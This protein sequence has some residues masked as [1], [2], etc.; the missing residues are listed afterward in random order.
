M[1]TWEE[2]NHYLK[3]NEE[4]LH[5]LDNDHMV[6]DGKERK[7]RLFSKV[8]QNT[9]AANDPIEDRS[10][11]VL[12][13][14][15]CFLGVFDGH[16]GDGC[17]QFLTEHLVDYTKFR[18][19]MRM[20]IKKQMK[21]RYPSVNFESMT[22]QE[23]DYEIANAL[24]ERQ[25]KLFVDMRNMF[26]YSNG[27]PLVLKESFVYTDSVYCKGSLVRM[28]RDRQLLPNDLSGSCAILAYIQRNQMWI[29]NTGDCRAVLA[30]RDANTNEL[31]AV[32]L[33]FDQTA[34]SEEQRLRAEFPNE[35]DIVLDG[36]IKGGLQPS[37]SFGDIMYKEP[38]IGILLPDLVKHQRQWNPPYV[39]S[40]PSIH[41]EE[42]NVATDEFIVIA[43][44]GLWDMFTN[45]EVIN[46]VETCN[47]DG[48]E[49]ACTYLIRQTLLRSG[50]GRND[51][52]KLSNLMQMPSNY[53]RMLHDDI[54]IQIAYINKS[55]DSQQQ[56]QVLHYE[57]VDYDHEVN[58]SSQYVQILK[59]FS[60]LIQDKS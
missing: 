30:R 38:V 49:N 51:C 31:I 17:A 6:S 1:L 53:R 41:H 18:L 44:D 34:E 46:M 55:Y 37:R 19:C 48:S 45:T 10:V 27:I 29:A 39:K 13:E 35:S 60:E 22:D 58:I 50:Y 4:L 59:D 57:E 26:H 40:E 8:E 15:E 14:E 25:R 36:R 12:D 24:D 54:T 5:V 3:Q 33:S 7:D 11:L 20:N 2:I 32:P 56:Q 43:S 52:E 47:T 23:W 42:I 21:Q 9:Y 16:A 28:I